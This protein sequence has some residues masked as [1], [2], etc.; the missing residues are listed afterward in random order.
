M[1]SR[2]KHLRFLIIDDMGDMRTSLRRMLSE[3]GAERFAMASNG[4]EALA[5]LEH[6]QFHVVL[7]DYNLG[8][9]KDGQQ[10]LEEARHRRLLPASTA[11]LMVT[12]ESSVPMVLG[13]LEYQPDDYL[14]KPFGSEVLQNRL[15][16]CIDRKRALAPLDRALADSDLVGALAQCD[17]LDRRDPQRAL[18]LDRVKA[19]LL[20]NLGRGAEAEQLYRAALDRRE[21]SWARHG[22]ARA[23]MLQGDRL[24][25]AVMLEALLRD[26]PRLPEAYDALADIHLAA[27]RSDLAQQVL[28][29]ATSLSPKTIRRQRRLATIATANGDVE[30]AMRAWRAAINNGRDSCF[31]SASEYSGLAQLLITVKEIARATAVLRDGRK[32][33]RGRPAEQVGIMISQIDLYASIG[34]EDE[35]SKLIRDALAMHERNPGVMLPDGL[36]A[37][38]RSCLQRTL[39]RESGINLLAELMR[40]QHDDGDIV[41]RVQALC[42][43]FELSADERLRIEFGRQEMIELNNDGVTLFRQGKLQDAAA[44]FL[45]AAVRL[46]QNRTVTLNAVKVT[47]QQMRING[48]DKELLAQVRGL[49]DRLRGQPDPSGGYS[50]SL[51]LYQSLL[52]KAVL[53]RTGSL[54]ADEGTDS[55]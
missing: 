55:Q 10:V 4:V 35:A 18:E 45:R 23:R 27:K 42:D 50:Q 6:K 40:N 3:L 24:G 7:C 44:L 15:R 37:L 2:L 28:E 13:A 30:V 34:Q 11:Y 32:Q 49:L 43:E 52:G 47:L 21:F 53:D 16:R 20:L 36:L 17:Q 29:R 9:G 12:A 5:A 41:A 14:V 48:P 19:D 8:D 39:W 26:E 25:A 1:P 51:R 22:L 54:I 38:A 33:F 31:S 46:P